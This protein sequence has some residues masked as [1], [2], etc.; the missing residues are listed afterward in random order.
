MR[1]KIFLKSL[2]I[3]LALLMFIFALPLNAFAEEVKTNSTTSSNELYIKDVKLTEGLSRDAA[4][5]ELENAKYIFFDH[6][7]NEGTGEGEV[8]L[9]YTT[10][11]D[12]SEAIYDMKLMNMK[13]GFT[14]TS[15]EK[16]IEAQS[17]AMEGVAN[18]LYVL[19]D[20][21]AKAY[22]AGSVPAQK[23]FKALNFFRMQEEKGTAIPGNGLGDKIVA[24]DLS[25]SDYLEIVLFCDA[26]LVDSIVQ[27]LCMGI[28]SQNRNWLEELSKVGPYDKKTDYKM[29]ASEL[30]K[31]AKQ[32]LPVL[33]IYAQ[34]YN[35]MEKTGTLSGTFNE[36]FEIE[37]QTPQ[38]STDVTPEDNS[39]K[40]LDIS[41]YKLYKIAFEELDKYTYG[42]ETLRSFFASLEDAYD[43]RDLYPLVSILSDGEYS[44]MTFGCVLDLILGTGI[45]DDAYANYDQVFAETTREAS[46]VY[47]YHGVKTI[48]LQEDTVIAF[49]DEANRHI[50]DTGEMEFY[51]NE[52][53]SENAWET[54]KNI[55]KLVSSIS[56]GIF[57][58]TKVA[59]LASM[60][61]TCTASVAALSAK[62]G[63]LGSIVKV[64]VA[65]GGLKGTI[66]AV[67]I[68]I[69]V[70]VA[71]FIISR[72]QDWWSKKIDWD[73]N[74][75]PEYIYDIKEINLIETSSSDS[76][77]TG[78][79][80][81][82]A[83]VF[84]EVVRNVQNEAV[85]LNAHSK[86]STEWL[87][88]YVSYDALDSTSKPI[89]ASD[90]LVKHGNGTTPDGYTPLSEFGE[91]IAKDLNS[92]DDDNSV[93][94]LY[95]FYKQDTKAL[96]AINRTYYISDIYLQTG[97][98]PEHCIALLEASSYTPI[99]V[100]LSPDYLDGNGNKVYSYIG[101]KLSASEDMAIRDIRMSYTTNA[102]PYN[103]GG[104]T[105][106]EHGTSAGVTLY[107]SKMTTTGT[108]ILAGSLIVT[109]DRDDAPDGYEPV[110]FFS[111]GPAM[112]FNFTG[113]AISGYNDKDYYLYFC[114]KIQF[115]S[116]TPYLGGIIYFKTLNK[117][118][119]DIMVVENNIR[120]LCKKT[121]IDYNSNLYDHF[122]QAMSQLVFIF[123]GYDYAATD[124]EYLSESVFYTQTYNPY[125][126]IY[127]VKLT[128]VEGMPDEIVHIQKGYSAIPSITFMQ[129]YLELP[130][131]VVSDSK[132]LF[133]Y[134][135]YVNLNGNVY[136]SGNP[137]ENTYDVQNEKM[138]GVQPISISEFICLPENETLEN[139]EAL[140]Y[141]CLSDMYFSD[142][143][144]L[145]IK[146][147]KAKY[148]FK[149]YLSKSEQ[150]N[151]PYI[152]RIYATDFASICREAGGGKAGFTV[153]RLTR[154]IALS[155]LGSKG[156]NF[157]CNE[158]TTIYGWVT[159]ASI[160]REIKAN[161]LYYGY[162]RTSKQAE[163]LTDMFLYYG[164]VSEGGDA[165]DY[166]YKGTIKY[167]LLCELSLYN[168]TG[169]E[170]SPAPRVYLYGTT[171]AA[172]GAK[173]TDFTT[174][175]SP[176]KENYETVKSY[177]G[178]SLW[179]EIY[180]SILEDKNH[181]P[182]YSGT[183]TL[184]QWRDFFTIQSDEDHGAWNR[185]IYLHIQ[186]EGDTKE[187]QKPYISELFLV[188]MEDNIIGAREKLFAMGADGFIE[189][190]LNEGAGGDTIY[191][192][193]KLTHDPSEAIT[194]ISAYHKKSHPETL[195]DKRGITYSLVSNIDLNDGAGLFSDYIY[196]YTTKDRSAGNPIVSV[197]IVYDV[198]NHGTVAY[199]SSGNTYW[200]GSVKTVTQW[201]STT[202]SDLN[203]NGGGEYLYLIYTSYYDS[204][205]GTYTEPNYGAAKKYTRTATKGSAEGAYIA[206]LYVMD[207]NT[208][209]QE[210]LAQGVDPDDCECADISDQE[211][212]DRLYS[213]GATAILDGYILSVGDNYS[214]F[215]KNNQNKIFIGYSRTDILRN[216]IKNIMLYTD[217]LGSG[218]PDETIHV[219]KNAY[220]LVAEP[221]SAVE[222]LPSA[223]N[224]IGIEDSQD[225][226][227]P[228]VYLYTSTSG[229]SPIYDIKLDTTEIINGWNTVLSQN[230]KEAF[231]D[232]S[233]AAAEMEDKIVKD[234][235]D[236]VCEASFSRH[237]LGGWYALVK[238]LF[239]PSERL[240][241][242]WYIHYKNYEGESLEETKP[243]IGEVYVAEGKTRDE[244]LRKLLNNNP[245]G[246]VD[247]N[248]N[249]GTNGKYV[250]IAYKRTDNSDL[251]GTALT[252]IALYKGKSPIKAH[253]VDLSEEISIRYNLVDFVSLNSGNGG[254]ELYLYSTTHENAGDLITSISI[255]KSALANGED[256]FISIGIN[257][258]SYTDGSVNLKSGTKAEAIYLSMVKPKPKVDTAET[259]TVQTQGDS[260]HSA[261][262][263]GN[264]SL[265]V[266][267]LFSALVLAAVAV[268]LVIK[269]KKNDIN[270]D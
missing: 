134:A 185:G 10:T 47:L 2:S 39:V 263:I 232:L 197:D 109:R 96:P 140:G 136:V 214:G 84:Y 53:W 135:S 25:V 180:E 268:G 35:A 58:T 9:G 264:G 112:T 22:K 7:L 220:K 32:L 101:Y 250:Y 179:S 228:K 154:G 152:S 30:E 244:A 190:D 143:G 11:T 48:L 171:N 100:N 191:L 257:D 199:D 15:L 256:T 146:N 122:N 223:I 159:N 16:S 157:F 133:N 192:G 167:S 102:S 193:Y 150:E 240:V 260:E 120:E 65:V 203:E 231:S 55:A 230:G 226:P 6:N 18:D 97:E 188:Q 245:D 200:T 113:Q 168:I 64:C 239:D 34:A 77:L 202:P 80:T 243:Y 115:T 137:A 156:A 215:D 49:T 210:K 222:K 144:P 73:S 110:N 82:P 52:T 217:P 81:S 196:L 26:T 132:F 158:P 187:E 75:I 267:G 76:V 31:R 270:N 258:G 85:D 114:P 155:T 139:A 78:Y 206:A 61:L 253:Y 43:T 93:N 14:L 201:D 173:I 165:P 21:F 44:A 252:D 71:S 4:K 60:A 259:E 8:Y 69:T 262:M 59:I 138:T 224:L 13:G 249:E 45:S 74:P 172:A 72:V 56:A 130:N 42:D 1:F 107:A 227:G 126:A 255:S 106:G 236:P 51:E 91:G 5:K 79:T 212:I 229:T 23:A 38:P 246:F 36:N 147:E 218:E 176:F 63:I 142:S 151:L 261:S 37:N 28:L 117:E 149:F 208:L 216:A 20:E 183:D 251:F 238:R 181:S 12:P 189:K 177:N 88:L 221:A 175:T 213:M 241:S 265:V 99:N 104:A 174:S 237:Y 195:T 194:D 24:G 160:K 248:L 123:S 111:G 247:Y 169:V 119:R 3:F 162:S 29:E 242:D 182:M 184:I 225:A 57:A 170:N 211:V 266:I 269:K 94:G 205:M 166:L 116:G 198:T 83:F 178:G 153:D 163:A 186:R 235:K 148:G 131:K 27:I 254:D 86:N 33:Q 129:T 108:P 219:N 95:F 233:S 204:P 92:Y 164:G 127:D 207:K 118:Y 121:G 67:L 105:Y 50:A 128:A 103:Y 161:S 62:S 17:L 70:Y 46:S 234:S 98:S 54:G 89:K 145:V 68:V 87:A 141:S 66:I 124:K 41:R 125:R 209:R 19:A 90:L 40:N